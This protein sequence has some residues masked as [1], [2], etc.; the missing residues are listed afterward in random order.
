MATPRR[1][2]SVADYGG[3][4]AVLRYNAEPVALNAAAARRGI[5][6]PFRQKITAAGIA[7]AAQ[8]AEP[9]PAEFSPSPAQCYEVFFGA[10]VAIQ[11]QTTSAIM[12]ARKIPS[13]TMLFSVAPHGVASSLAQ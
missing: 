1:H 11:P 7:P 9:S 13:S 2:E 6:A 10:R 4:W 5:A 8:S 3:R 12:T